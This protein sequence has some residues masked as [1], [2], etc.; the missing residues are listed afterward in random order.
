MALI[1]TGMDRNS[2][3]TKTLA[4]ECKFYQIRDTTSSRIANGSYFIDIYG[5][6]GHTAKF[7][8]KTGQKTD[9]SLKL[10]MND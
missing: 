4:V 9:R 10:F 1:G 7:K 6:L 5:K 3:G 2:L 8:K